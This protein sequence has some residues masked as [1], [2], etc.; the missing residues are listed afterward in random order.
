MNLRLDSELL[1][2][3]LLQFL[4]SVSP[5]VEGQ[6]WSIDFKARATLPGQVMGSGCLGCWVKRD[7]GSTKNVTTC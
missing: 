4:A 2:K 5:S 3:C 6:L 7:S 1:D